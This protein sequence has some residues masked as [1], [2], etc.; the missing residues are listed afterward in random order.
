M[1]ARLQY[2]SQGNNLQNIQAACEA[3]CDWIQLR[4]KDTA[5][6][7]V[8]EIA[9]AARQI[10]DAHQA[11]LIINDYPEIAQA[12]KADGV[13]LGKLD[14]SHRV[15]R[16][17]LGKDFIVGGT[18][19]TIADIRKYASEGAVDYIG[20][21]PFRYTTT[22]QNLSPIL[23]VEGYQ[24]IID[25][26]KVEAIDLPIIAIGGIL[27]EDITDIVATGVHGIALS[28]LITKAE[29]KTALI[30]DIKSKLG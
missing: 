16:K 10:C 28:G 2:I 18:A 24:R 15:A 14:T 12:V 27:L 23:G 19:N 6:V 30:A 4:V 5:L 9:Q 7:E 20:L 11:K 3:G 26:C 13:H 1:I 29:D 25:Q 22:K 8:L 17:L 21:G